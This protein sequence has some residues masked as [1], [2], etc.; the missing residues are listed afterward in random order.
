MTALKFRSKESVRT[1]IEPQNEGQQLN[2]VEH[3][4]GPADEV[5]A[6][7]RGMRR[8]LADALPR[9]TVTIRIVNA[10]DFHDYVVLG[11]AGIVDKDGKIVIR[12]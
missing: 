4:D 3:Y 2:Y 12:F 6:Y 9:A 10:D 7:A 11:E 5:F 8:K 1:I